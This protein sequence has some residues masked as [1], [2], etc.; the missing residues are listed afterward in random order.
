MTISDELILLRRTEFRESS[1][2]VTALSQHHGKMAL[3]AKGV[4]KPKSSWGGL[5]QVGQILTAQM[6]V[7]PTRSVQLLT[8]V[9]RAVRLDSLSVEIEKMAVM[10]SLMELLD[11]LLHEGEINEPVYLFARDV[12][13]WMENE[14]TMESSLFPYLQLRL[15]QL[16][17]L[18]MQV[19]QELAD[20]MDGFLNIES[21]RLSAEAETTHA[22]RLTALQQTFLRRA[23]EFGNRRLFSLGMSSKEARGLIQVLDRY[24]GY[25]LEGIRPRKSDVV[26]EQIF[27]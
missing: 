8:D 4:R 20:G 21:G 13:V 14:P 6:I 22:M 25:H 18:E 19:D 9:T 23:I 5:L 3:I 15:V 11:Q 17:G 16:S 24:F 2:I 27:K 12:L 7:K 26:F 10:M 1:L